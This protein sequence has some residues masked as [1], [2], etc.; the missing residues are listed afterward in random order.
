MGKG[1]RNKQQTMENLMYFNG[2]GTSSH[3]GTPLTQEEAEKE[4]LAQR[5][6]MRYLLLEEKKSILETMAYQDRYKKL[7]DEIWEDKVKLEGIIEKEEENALKR[8]KERYCKKK[9][10]QE[11]LYFQSD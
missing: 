5:I 9:K 8:L 10:T 4:S 1:N 7:I 3:N 6:K 2:I 11:N